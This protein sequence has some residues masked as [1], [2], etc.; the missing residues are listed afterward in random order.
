MRQQ[1]LIGC[2]ERNRVKVQH[3]ILFKLKLNGTDLRIAIQPKGRR[4]LQ[5]EAM[6]HIRYDA[7]AVIKIQGFEEIQG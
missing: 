6:E 2:I 1:F 7:D 4:V 3:A 5:R